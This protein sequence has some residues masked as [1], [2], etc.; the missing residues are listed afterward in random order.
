MDHIIQDYT[1]YSCRVVVA[2]ILLHI[3][4]DRSASLSAAL[5]C[6]AVTGVRYEVAFSLHMGLHATALRLRNTK[7][8]FLTELITVEIHYQLYYKNS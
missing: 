2:Y 6:L 1:S 7:L 3:V 4:L 8:K 5:L